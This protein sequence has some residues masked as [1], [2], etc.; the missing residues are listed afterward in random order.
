[1]MIYVVMH[2][3]YWF[4]CWYVVLVN[5]VMNLQVH[6]KALN[7]FSSANAS[8]EGLLIHLHE[9]K[10][11]ECVV[12]VCTHIVLINIIKLPSVWLIFYFTY[13]SIYFPVS[14]FSLVIYR[15]Q[16]TSWLCVMEGCSS[17]PY[18]LIAV[19]VLLTDYFH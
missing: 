8:K 3:L 15:T 9:S 6:W 11:D 18:L 10:L 14:Y 4:Q 13:F 12:L 5:T 7:L 17:Q 2:L 1:M 19:C 16:A